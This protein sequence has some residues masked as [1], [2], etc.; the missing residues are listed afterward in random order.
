MRHMG[1]CPYHIINVWRL[2]I[3][4]KLF[5]DVY[6]IH[7]FDIITCFVLLYVKQSYVFCTFICSTMCNWGFRKWYHY[8]FAYSTTICILVD[9]IPALHESDW[10]SDKTARS[11]H[12][13]P[14]LQYYQCI[15][16]C[17]CPSPVNYDVTCQT[18]YRSTDFFLKCWFTSLNADESHKWSMHRIQG[19]KRL[20]RH[21]SMN[22]RHLGFRA[23]IIHN[24]NYEYFE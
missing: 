11:S 1:L 12:A 21:F 9:I 8:H 19:A 7:I 23:D 6:V 24:F 3:E 10:F 13:A 14:S 15:Y 2:Y 20:S 18:I 5:Q 17:R 22:T 4:T 16:S